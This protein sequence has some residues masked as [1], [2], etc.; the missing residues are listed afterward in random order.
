M[1]FDGM[2]NLSKLSYLYGKYM[3]VPNYYYFTSVICVV[4]FTF[5]YL[6][7]SFVYRTTTFNKLLLQD[8]CVRIESHAF[9]VRVRMCPDGPARAASLTNDVSYFVYHPHSPYLLAARMRVKE[10][11]YIMQVRLPSCTIPMHT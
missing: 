3:S 7:R 1:I 5:S 11:V 8:V 4:L 2:T 9:W 6:T 10:A